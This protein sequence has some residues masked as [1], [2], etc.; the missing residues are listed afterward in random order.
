MVD[1]YVAPDRLRL[2]ALIQGYGAAALAHADD[3]EHH[4]AG[5][6]AGRIN[7][8]LQRGDFWEDCPDGAEK[9]VSTVRKYSW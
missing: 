8:I 3:I 4:C 6:F 2:P 1:H 7:S 5:L 9:G